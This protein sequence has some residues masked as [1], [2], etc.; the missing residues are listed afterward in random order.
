MIYLKSNDFFLNSQQPIITELREPQESYPEHSHSFEEIVIVSSGNGTHVINEVPMKLSKNY[1]CFVNRKDR[2]LFE[3]VDKLHL[4]NVLFDRSY[5]SIDSALQKYIPNET[6]PSGWFINESI[7]NHI[8]NII[9]TIHKESH[10]NSP[11]SKIICQSLFN[12]LLVELTRGKVKTIT[13]ET[14]E[15]KATSV[16]SYLLENYAMNYSVEEIADQ[17]SMSAKQLTN[18][19]KALTGMSYNR[20]LNYVRASKALQLLQQTDKSVTEIAYDVGYQDSNYFSTKF[21]QI[22]NVKPR[23]IRNR[24]DEVSKFNTV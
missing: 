21:K 17:A 11:E 18:K 10:S 3:N 9:N 22:F 14:E 15:E 7:G 2:H 4:S 12:I 8:Q 5:L 19:L 1:V 13:G 16:A 24:R 20:Y 23:D 6:G